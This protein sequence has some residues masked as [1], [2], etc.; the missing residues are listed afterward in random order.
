MKWL[1]LTVRKL[2]PPGYLRCIQSLRPISKKDSF[3]STARTGGYKGTYCKGSYKNDLLNAGQ[4]LNDDSGRK[5]SWQKKKF[6][7]MNSG[8]VA[9]RTSRKSLR[10]AEE[11]AMASNFTGAQKN[12]NNDRNSPNSIYKSSPKSYIKWSDQKSGGLSRLQEP[13]DEHRPK[14][15]SQKNSLPLKNPSYKHREPTVVSSSTVGRRESRSP[16][17]DLNDRLYTENRGS[18]MRTSSNTYSRSTPSYQGD[19]PKPQRKV[20]R[21][22]SYYNPRLEEDGKS[23]LRGR[24]MKHSADLRNER[25][26]SGT[27]RDGHFQKRYD[28]RIK[29]EHS[30]M[31]TPKTWKGRDRLDKENGPGFGGR[32]FVETA[33]RKFGG[34]FEGFDLFP[35][36]SQ[37]P[38]PFR[39]SKPSTRTLMKA[40]PITD[41]EGKPKPERR[42]RMNSLHPTVLDNTLNSHRSVETLTGESSSPNYSSSGSPN[43]F[44]D[45]DRVSRLK[46][47]HIKSKSKRSS[48]TG[49]VFESVPSRFRLNQSSK[50]PLMTLEKKVTW[51]ELGLGSSMVE[52]LTSMNI[53]KPNPMQCEVIPEIFVDQSV[54]LCAAETGS[55]KTLA[56][57]VPI[58]EKLKREEAMKAQSR[59][60]Q[61][62]RAVILVPSHELVDQVFRIAKQLS[63][64]LKLRCTKI[65]SSDDPKVVKRECSSMIDLLVST[66][67]ALLNA[68]Q[69]GLLQLDSVSHLSIDEAD[70][71]LSDDFGQDIRTL[72]SKFKP[73]LD[74]A[75]LASA[76]IPVSLTMLL[77]TLFPTIKSLASPKLHS[78]SERVDIEFYDMML[79]GNVKLS[80]ILNFHFVN[81][82]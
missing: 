76:T 7:E 35:L 17:N 10:P 37:T 53:H 55:G 45:S 46:Q 20:L 21:K 26:T 5:D 31:S 78:A 66:P 72:L 9:D 22:D 67:A 38:I 15:S 73:R 36:S 42:E 24:S 64:H 59:Q 80:R 8:N 3:P 11:P 34:N 71:L 63:H 54:F 33:S 16:G 6:P 1:S 43:E 39:P 79:P 27:S 18:A 51:A 23:S 32:G 50:F 62:P 82:F 68:E 77:K 14:G 28:D 52:A 61:R 60:Q 29:D 49:E 19:V 2:Y 40:Q 74:T 13:R 70:T 41:F 75:V 47:A 30:G 81:V 44:K 57:L 4:R 48:E 56:Y 58:M 65:A 69:D 25:D 12:R